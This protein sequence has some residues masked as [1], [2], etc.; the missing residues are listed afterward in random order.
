PKSALWFQSQA[1]PFKDMILCFSEEDWPLLNPGQ[2]GFYGEFIIGE[3]CGVSVTPSKTQLPDGGLGSLPGS[4]LPS[5]TVHPEWGL[6]SL[7]S[8]IAG[9]WRCIQVCAWLS[10]ANVALVPAC[11]FDTG[12]S[13]FPGCLSPEAQHHYLLLASHLLTLKALALPLRGSCSPHTSPPP[14]SFLDSEPGCAGHLGSHS[15]G[16]LAFPW[17]RGLVAPLTSLVSCSWRQTTG[18]GEHGAHETLETQKP[19]RCGSC[20]RSFRHNYHL[21]SHQRIH[22]QPNR[23]EPEMQSVE[24]LG[25]QCQ[26][27]LAQH[28]SHTHQKDTIRA[29]QHCYCI[30]SFGQN[31]DIFCH[32]CVHM[33]R[34]SK[35]ALN[36]Y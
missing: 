11:H 27:P 30:K 28:C 23:L 12:G 3:D 34:C 35:Q 20:G 29:F 22:R 7:P 1:S 19:Y 18:P 36:S 33:K 10:K 4:P 14:L 26:E 8:V 9:D 17:G 25:F 21:L 31:L 5:E 16:C 2:T 15:M 24:G 32:E 6:G 13:G